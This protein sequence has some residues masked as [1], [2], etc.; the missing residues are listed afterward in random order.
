MQIVP[1]GE[2]LIV[3]AKVAPSDIAFIRTGQTA[4]VKFDAYDSSIYGSGE[5]TVTFVSPDT[6]SERGA[7]GAENL[8]YCVHLTVDTGQ[9]DPHRAGRKTEQKPAMTFSH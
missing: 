9:M 8:F 7:D 1:T 3:E 4:N 2:E 5:G 6:I